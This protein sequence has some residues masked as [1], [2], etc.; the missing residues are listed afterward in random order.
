MYQDFEFNKSILFLTV[1]A[2]AAFGGGSKGC[3][4]A[5]KR[6]AQLKRYK[7]DLENEQ[8]INNNNGI[9]NENNRKLNK[10]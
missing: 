5:N 8:K 2:L 3:H 10:T 6:E 4:E 7:R 1:R 9:T